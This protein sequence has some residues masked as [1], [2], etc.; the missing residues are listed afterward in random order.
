MNNLEAA[1][2]DFYFVRVI[3]VAA[4]FGSFFLYTIILFPSSLRSLTHRLVQYGC[5]SKKPTFSE[6]RLL[7]YPQL[8]A[9]G[10][11]NNGD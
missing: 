7:T 9:S 6:Q 1:F 8:A 2:F 4:T 11:A 5:S 10:G 3:V